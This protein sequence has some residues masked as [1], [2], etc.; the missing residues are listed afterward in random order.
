MD[1]RRLDRDT[2]VLD[3]DGECIIVLYDAS[4]TPEEMSKMSASSAERL[5]RRAKVYRAFCE[6]LGTNGPKYLRP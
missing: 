1:V 4:I 5:E 2:V 6:Q 3:P